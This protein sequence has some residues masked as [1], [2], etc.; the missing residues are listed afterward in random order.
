MRSDRLLPLF[1]LF[2]GLGLLAGCGGG[3][4][5]GGGGSSPPPASSGPPVLT[6]A[7][8]GSNVMTLTVNG[9][10]CSAAFNARYPDKPCVAVTMCDANGN[11]CQ[12][13]DDILLDTGDYGFRIFQQALNEPILTAL[14]D[15]A[16]KVN[17]ETVYECIEYGDGSRVWG[18]VALATLNSTSPVQVPIQVIGSNTSDAKSGGGH[19]C[20]DQLATVDDAGYNGSLGLGFF[21]QDC[22]AGCEASGN[23]LYWTCG[24]GGCS[25]PGI[26]LSSQVGNPVA[27]L[28]VDN[29]GVFVSLPSVLTTGA[30]SVTG[31]VIFGINTESNNI[32]SP[33]VTAYGASSSTGY[34]TTTF[35]GV[36][37]T[38]GFLD[39]GSNGIFVSYTGEPP[40]SNG[41]YTPPSALNLSATTTGAPNAPNTSPAIGFQIANATTLFASGNNVFSNLAGP[42]PGGLMFDWGL[43]FFLGRNVYIGIENTS[44]TIN[45]V[46]VTGPFWAY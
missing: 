17:N 16:I 4:G 28:P 15:N 38:Q 44:S 43:P 24:G 45:S 31:S 22:G 42:L 40:S 34:F 19:A 6:L 35:N 5:G 21:A 37:Y 33:G 11:N 25:S 14:N 41:F 39:T 3:G 30:V 7:A 8:V 18:P 36:Q 32:P 1:M 20:S 10:T 23:T 29:N 46:P 9:S 2:L 26:P 13:I 27:T 12:T